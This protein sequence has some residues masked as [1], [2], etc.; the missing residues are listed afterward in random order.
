MYGNYSRCRVVLLLLS[1]LVLAAA[2][3]PE[4]VPSFSHQGRLLDEN[5]NI[6]PDDDYNVEYRIYHV[7]TGGTPVY[8]EN[9][10]VTVKDGLFTTSLGLSGTMTPTIFS[11]PAWLEIVVNGEVLTPRQ[12][13]QGAPYAF[14]LASGSVVQGVEPLDRTYLT[15]EKTGA[16]M[17][18]LNNDVSAEGGNGLLAVNRAAAPTSE[19]GNVAALQARALGGIVSESTG[20]AGAI[21]SSAAYRGLIVQTDAS[22]YYSAAFN[23]GL[24][25]Y[26]EGNCTGCTMAYL[27]QNVG[28]APINAGDFVAV[29][30]VTVDAD[31]NIPV[32]QVRRATGPGDAIIG[33]A[34]SAISRSPVSVTNGVT[35]GGFDG[36]DGPAAAGGYLS[37]AVQGLV[38]A[39]AADAAMAP[40]ASL[41]AGPDGAVVATT[42]NGFARALS[43]VDG[44]G[45]VWVMLGGQ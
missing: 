1:F 7:S 16:S 6:V 45:L 39:R 44:A 5:G 26:V 37:V 19:R 35:T 41:T 33:V 15:L 25:I 38:Q 10:V 9:Q 18:V 34:T 30:G 4:I 14:S 2:C 12:N 3:A 23:G 27:A 42:G 40:G 43:N 29:E 20:S 8:T 21:I 32:M 28:D 11:Q 22:A 31:M 36:A 17:V 13:L 24:G